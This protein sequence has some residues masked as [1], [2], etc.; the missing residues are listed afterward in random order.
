MSADDTRDHRIHH[1]QTPWDYITTG[2]KGRE[3]HHLRDATG[4]TLATMVRT[5]DVERIVACVNACE[6]LEHPENLPDVITNLHLLAAALTT[7]G[8]PKV[9]NG[10]MDQ[11]DRLGVS[12]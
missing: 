8:M 11:L 5:T 9:A 7:N 12:S 3:L 1:G 4:Y 10:L 6:E 2:P